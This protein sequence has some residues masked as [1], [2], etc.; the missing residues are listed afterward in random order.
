MKRIIV[1]VKRSP[2]SWPVIQVEMSSPNPK[3]KLASA[4]SAR[5]MAMYQRAF[6]R[7]ASTPFT[8]RERP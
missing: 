7:S 3:A 5:P 6:M 2:V 1:L 4:Q 8:K